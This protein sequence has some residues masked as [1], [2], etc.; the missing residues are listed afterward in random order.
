MQL[1]HTHEDTLTGHVMQTTTVPGNVQGT[2]LV[3]K[4]L[5]VSTSKAC[6]ATTHAQPSETHSTLEQG[7]SRA[8]CKRFTALNIHI[9]IQAIHQRTSHP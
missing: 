2:Y 8:V 4:V 3:H 1:L 7:N 9:H 5:Q 6:A